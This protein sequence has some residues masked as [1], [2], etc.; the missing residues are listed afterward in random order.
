MTNVT[1]RLGLDIRVT[2]INIQSGLSKIYNPIPAFVIPN[3]ELQMTNDECYRQGNANGLQWSTN[4]QCHQVNYLH[5]S[6]IRHSLF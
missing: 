1:I 2:H 3:Y 5:Q 6:R 4:H